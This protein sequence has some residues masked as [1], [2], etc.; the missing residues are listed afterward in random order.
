M[1]SSLIPERPILVSPSLAATIGLEEATML[2]VL[3][4]LTRPLQ[5]VDSQ[6]FRWFE[7]ND[8]T[9]YV[10]LPFWNQHDINRIS[11]NLRAKGILL[12]QSAPFVQSQQ[13]IFAFNEPQA[14]VQPE[15][16]SNPQAPVHQPQHQPQ[17]NNGFQPPIQ[18]QPQHHPSRQPRPSVAVGAT[19]IAPNWQPD[20]EML[21]RIAQHN[22]PEHFIREQLPEFVTFWR[23]SGEAHRSWGAKFHQHVLHQ[24]RQRET[25]TTQKDSEVAMTRDWRPSPDAMDVLTRHA[26]IH[27]QFIE[28]AIP[29]FIL[30]WAERGERSRTWNT[31]FIQHIRRQWARYTSALEH[32]SEP[33]RIPEN[34]QP[35]SDVYDILRMANIDVSFAQQL[36]PEFLI[37]WRDSNQVY[38]SW[39]TKFLQHVKFHW[40]KRH[41]LSSSTVNAPQG[42]NHEGQQ[43]TTQPSRTRDRSIAEDLNDRSWAF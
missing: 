30:Y 34:W 21:A 22:I 5:P 43:A 19:A 1:T 29:E 2:S 17:S 25:F 24:W 18:S 9:L 28:D 39:N 37:F 20:A 11:Q 4:E 16:G 15:A 7:L 32:D 27:P 31:K 35:G 36:L 26:A 14:N 42:R 33:R 10:A 40:A 12:L 6:G 41:S 3:D 13:L 8:Q 23:E 38:A